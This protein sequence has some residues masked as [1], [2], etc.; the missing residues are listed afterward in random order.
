MVVADGHEDLD[1]F[2][3]GDWF[4]LLVDSTIGIVRSQRGSTASEIE[5]IRLRE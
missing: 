1:V 4:T 5:G 3:K 2:H